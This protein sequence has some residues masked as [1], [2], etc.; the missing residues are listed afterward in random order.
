MTC[1]ESRA[2]LVVGSKN[3]FTLA[4]VDECKRA[5]SLSPYNAGKLVFLSCAG[6]RTEITLTVPGSNP[7]KGEIAVTITPTQA[8]DMDDGWTSADLE[9]TNSLS[10][11][12]VIPL[13]DQF[14]I[15]KRN[16]PPA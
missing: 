8:E 2:Q 14:E 3:Q 16:C 7:D 15:I 1:V 11:L 12:T 9:L 4:V 10:E 13:N 6:V 5:I